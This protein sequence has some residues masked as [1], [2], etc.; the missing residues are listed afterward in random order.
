MILPASVAFMATPASVELV[1]GPPT[2]I[3][4]FST[5]TRVRTRPTTPTI[6]VVGVIRLALFPA[7]IARSACNTRPGFEETTPTMT[8]SYGLLD[9]WTVGGP[10]VVVTRLTTSPG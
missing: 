5:E 3:R 2:T 7:R 1:S 4:P 10:E 6:V 9:F 8:L